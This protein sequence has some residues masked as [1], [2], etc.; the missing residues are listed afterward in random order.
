MYW[1]AAAAKLKQQPESMRRR[2][3]IVEHPY[4]TIKHCPGR[5]FIRVLDHVS[6]ADVYMGGI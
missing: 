5:R 1:R 3:A 2:K 6:G 4:A